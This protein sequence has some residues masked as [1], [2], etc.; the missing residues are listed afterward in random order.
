MRLLL[1][2]ESNKHYGTNY[3][4]QKDDSARNLSHNAKL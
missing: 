4:A 3:L 1:P 2:F